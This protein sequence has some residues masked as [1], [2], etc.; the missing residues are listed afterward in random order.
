[1]LAKGYTAFGDLL[2]RYRM[3]AG[4]TQEI[5]AERAAISVRAISDLERGVK[6]RPRLYTLQQL[7]TTLGLSDSE[8][9]AFV[10]AARS[11]PNSGSSDGERQTHPTN[12][13]AELTSFIGRERELAA[14][15]ALLRKPE[16]RLLTLTGPGGTGK[17]RLGRRVAANLLSSY[18]DGVFFV[19]LARLTDP[20]LVLPTIATTLGIQ[21][22]G[23]QPLRKRLIEY[24]LPK[25]ILLLLDN[26]EHL[27]AA[28]PEVSTLLEHCASLSVLTTSREPL[29]LYGEQQFPVPPLAAPLFESSD[30]DAG[31]MDPV[32][33]RQSDAVQL[34][35]DRAQAV[36]PDFALTPGNA[37]S[38]AAI[39]RYLDGL[40]LAIELAAACLEVLPPQAILER[41]AGRLSV[42][43]GRAQNVDQR[44]RTMWDT[45]AWSYD[46]L[47][48]EEQRLFRRIA[49]FA[50]GCVIE[51]VEAVNPPADDVLDLITSLLDKGLV[52]RREG[53]GGEPRFGMLATIRTFG[54]ECL[55]DQE[56]REECRRAHAHYYLRLAEQAA[57][58]LRGPEQVPWLERLEEEHD[59]LR[60]ALRWTVEC[61]EQEYGLQLA[62]NLEL[63]WV[64]HGH[65]IE[66]R[67]WLDEM[68]AVWEDVT[69]VTLAKA[70][71]ANGLLVSAQ[72]ENER[73][74]AL[75]EQSLHLYRQVNNQAGIAEVLSRLANAALD[76][77]EPARGVELA[78]ES[79]AL[80]RMLDNRM[81][82]SVAL[83]TL[84]SAL[85]YQSDFDRATQLYEEC[86]ILSRELGGKSGIAAALVNLTGM[87]LH[88]G[89]SS[90]AVAHGEEAL[91]LF[92]ELGHKPGL[93]ASL[94]V[95]GLATLAAGDS[96]RSVAIIEECLELSRQLGDT[97]GVI[98]CAEEMACALSVSSEPALAACL[99]GAAVAAR[100]KHET[101]LSEFDRLLYEPY[102]TVIR[103]RLGVS[104]FAAAYER[105]RWTMLDRAI[106]DALQA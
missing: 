66:G 33:L 10:Q 84:A 23:E 21:D 79:V 47:S 81:A 51:A 87:A 106:E 24:L 9:A 12:L 92:Q 39:C 103:E 97:V 5:L 75:Y 18:P 93:E 27:M 25:Q 105:G 37:S 11:P 64:W 4:L 22:S 100:E 16:I 63:F 13:P 57:R 94:L 26:F 78:E 20:Q 74:R 71:S 35:M 68:L 65:V 19:P 34:F 58:E 42:L 72:G 54:L 28:A 61:N 85:L 31:A 7:A 45:I 49:Y 43:T 53:P 104:A 29:H 6:T 73:A 82:L 60:L 2:R 77:G 56:E 52:R 90:R 40:P 14:V 62:G 76:Q 1:M 17:T 48:T 98:D 83:R 102:L 89:N 15:P 99:W 36:Q 101:P 70:T 86:L 67:N 44:Q 38:V 88:E 30:G 55:Q 69:A 50:G 59:N 46:L 91:A 96:A 8:H 3:D 80:Y 95:L 41:L 32:V